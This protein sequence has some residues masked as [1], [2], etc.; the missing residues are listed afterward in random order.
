MSEITT[1]P[2]KVGLMLPTNEGWM[3]GGMARWSDLKTMAQHA[4]AVGFDSLWLADH[5]LFEFGEVGEPPHGVWEAWSVLSALAA[6]TT[7]VQ[8][9]PLVV[10]TSFRNPTLLAKMTDTL[11]EISGGR[12]ILGLGAGYHEREYRAF[13]YPFDHLVSRFE[14]ALRIIHTLLRVGEIDFHGRY[15]DALACELRPRG[16]RV[17]GPGLR[18][19]R[20]AGRQRL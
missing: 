13:G 6:V 8:L 15:Y 2:L 1:R 7:R 14:E 10:C 9:G 16:P 5:L 20:A 18:R 4:E 19:R 3:A 12:L 11:D 17:S